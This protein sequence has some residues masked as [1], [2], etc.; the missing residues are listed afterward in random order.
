VT[1]PHIDRALWRYRLLAY[2]T[3]TVLLINV[4]VAVPLQIAGH[5]GFGDVS[6][7]VHGGLFIVYTVT[8]LGLAH[9]LRWS[10]VRT[11]LVVLAGTIPVMTFVAERKVVH[12]V[13]R[14]AGGAVPV[15]EQPDRTSRVGD[16][17]QF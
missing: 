6:W 2:V 9:R 4:V 7:T 8:V 17:D 16:R 5:P 13:R 12:A 11:G 10:L 15:A 3:G 14:E 1:S